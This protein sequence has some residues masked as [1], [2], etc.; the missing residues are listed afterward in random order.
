MAPLK[1]QVAIT[2][3]CLLSACGTGHSQPTTSQDI[4]QFE[5][6]MRPQDMVTPQ[7]YDAHLARQIRNSHGLM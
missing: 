7:F 3:L 4:V 2:T 6:G 1:Y 5:P